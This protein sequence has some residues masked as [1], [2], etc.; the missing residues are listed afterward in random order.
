MGNFYV[1]YTLKGVTQQSVVAA[2]AGRIA[3]ISPVSGDAVVVFDSLSDKQDDKIITKLGAKLSGDLNAPCVA[4][5][6]HDDD[7][8]WYQ[9]FDGGKLVDEY[10][11]CPDYFDFDGRG[12]RRDPS[13]GDADKLCGLFGSKQVDSVEQILRVSAFDENGYAFAFQR[14]ADLFEELGLPSFAVGAGYTYMSGGEL[15]EGLS[16]SNLIRTT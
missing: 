5:L 8:L 3:A 11:S 4:I 7:I 1:N 9:L 6:N 12:T 2:M 10:N 14:H 15:P 13:G 16:E